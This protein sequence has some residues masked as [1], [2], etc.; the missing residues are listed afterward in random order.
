MQR[1]C[2]DRRVERGLSRE[3]EKAWYY[4]LVKL[5]TRPRSYW[6]A[7]RASTAPKGYERAERFVVNNTSCRQE[8]GGGWGLRVGWLGGWR[9]WGALVGR[10]RRQQSID[11]AKQ[12]RGEMESSRWRQGSLK[13]W[14]EKKHTEEA[15]DGACLYV[16][17]DIAD[18]TN[19]R[20]GVSR[21][22]S[23]NALTYSL[24]YRSGRLGYVT[25][26]QCWWVIGLR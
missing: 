21:T 13:D 8:S 24:L 5:K 4:R 12:R 6:V 14:G 23:L 25:E 7:A 10:S 16:I 18:E 19:W 22:T 9:G 17:A 3:K 2:D 11:T 26:Y 1:A 15:W 20:T